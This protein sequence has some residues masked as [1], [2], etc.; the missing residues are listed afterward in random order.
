MNPL[1]S[2]H[3]FGVIILLAIGLTALSLRFVRPVD[4]Q[5]FCNFS[6]QT[7]CPSGSCRSGEQRAGLPLPILVDSGGGSS[8]TGGW[9]RLGPEDLPNPVTPVLD[10][11]FYSLILWLIMY[12]IRFIRGKEKPRYALR[13]EFL[14]LILPLVLVLACLMTG[15]FLYRPFLTR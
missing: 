11:L 12:L 9:G 7:P 1:N 6:R 3:S 4:C 5:A 8:P 14:S 2:I 13:R 15:F 10:V